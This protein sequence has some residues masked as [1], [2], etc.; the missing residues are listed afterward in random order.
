MRLSSRTEYGLK[1]MIE[2]AKRQ[3]DGRATPA[4]EIASSQAIP[5]RFLEQQIKALRGAGL[6]TCQRGPGGGCR[7]TKPASEIDLR[8]IVE[9]LEGTL[10]EFVCLDAR[11]RACHADGKCGLQEVWDGCRNVLS[12]YLSGINLADLAARHDSLDASAE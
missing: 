10:V 1:A 8:Q 4:R 12:E 6:V 11:G 9:A 7:L 2:L 3:A 5:E